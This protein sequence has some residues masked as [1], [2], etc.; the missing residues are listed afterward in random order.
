MHWFKLP[1]AQKWRDRIG[2]FGP[3]TNT[4]GNSMKQPLIDGE[5]PPFATKNVFSGNAG[6]PD[7][8]FGVC[9]C[10]GLVRERNLGKHLEKG[11]SMPGLD[12]YPSMTGWNVVVTPVIKPYDRC[13]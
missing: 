6:T 10:C 7:G 11:T 2:E 1:R 5:E 8:F 13:H 3:P 9:K 12:R 4:R